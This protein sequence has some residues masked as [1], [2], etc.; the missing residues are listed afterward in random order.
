MSYLVLARK[1]RPQTFSEVIGQRPVV[2]TLQ[3]AIRRNRVPHALIFSGVR[4]VGK[5]TLAR[6]MA[7]A[8]N[9]QQGP[10]P[11]PCNVCDSCAAITA[12]TALDIM[13]IDGASNRGIQE[14]R[15]LKENI[16]FFPSQARY[17]IV[18]VDEVHMLTT[19]AFNAL[20]KTIEEPPAHV[21][22]MFATTELHKVPITILSRCQR[23]E[24]K[25]V[26]FDELLAFLRKISSAE[27]VTISDQALTLIAREAE[28]SV[29]DGLSLLDQIFSFGGESVSDQD[30]LEVLGLVD[31][32]IL[33]E[34]TGTLLAQ[35]LEKS[36]ALLD[37][38]YSF[39]V[40]IKRFC[41][42]LLIYFRGALLCKISDR[43]EEILDL[44]DQELRR[45]REISSGYSQESL[46]QCF[47]VLLR[48]VEEMQYASHPK[49]VLEMSFIKAVESGKVVPV[50]SLIERLDR[51]LLEGGMKWSSGSETRPQTREECRHDLR[52]VPVVSP[53]EPTMQKEQGAVEQKKVRDLQGSLEEFRQHVKRRKPWMAHALRLAARWEES[54]RQLLIRFDNQADCVVLQELEN[55]KLLTEL[56][57][58]F[59]QREWQIKIVVPGPVNQEIEGVTEV[60][61]QE[62]RRTLA[63]DPLV[64]TAL[65]IFGGEISAIRTGPQSR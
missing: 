46:Y 61:A 64:T 53:A 4:G 2:L 41:Q 39:G 49:L 3:N 29:R 31:R 13:E 55:L 45:L 14:I 38:V 59:F 63:N 24:L 32:Q 15:D 56:A 48:G 7:K 65:G 57:Q 37:R 9:C 51:L 10:I 23:H 60:T 27:Q 5:T 28:G 30:V 52:P 6:I 22:F 34:L 11:E 19:E 25:R 50:S 42:D 16:R 62:D 21:Y 58:D 17:K 12:G 40:D 1:W 20:L 36:L 43:A 18:I 26:L 35:D 47:N 8:L 44:P 54:D 33:E